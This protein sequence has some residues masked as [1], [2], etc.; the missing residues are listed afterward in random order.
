MPTFLF[1]PTGLTV[2]ILG[3]DCRTHSRSCYDHH[4]CG[5][6]LAED[7]VVCFERLQ[8]IVDDKE[9]S[10]IAT[11]HVLNGINCYCVCFLKRILTRFSDLYEDVLAQIRSVCPGSSVAVIISCL[12][13]ETNKQITINSVDDTNIED[14][15]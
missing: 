2:K 15:K 12:P 10:S 3:M 7:V 11:Y 13:E 14:L 8:I 4:T 1:H 9:K 6:L 5:S